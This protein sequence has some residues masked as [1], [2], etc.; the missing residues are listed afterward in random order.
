MRKLPRRNADRFGVALIAA[1]LWSAACAG[2]RPDALRDALEGR[3]AASGA[4][5][6]LYFRDLRTGD[7][8]LVAPDLR[9]HAASM[10]KVPV[11]IQV[12]RDAEAGRLRLEDTVAVT[13]AF[14]SIMDGSPYEL[15]IADDSDR[16]LY[17]RRRATVRELVDRMITVSSNLA[18]NLLIELVGA[19]RVTRTMR[20]LGADS[21][22]VLRGVEDIK[23]YEAG[24]SN[25]TTA[26]DLGVIFGAIAECRAASPA[27]CGGM[28][29]ILAR[30]A[31][32]GGIPAG[33]PAGTRV[34]HKT[35]RITR[36]HHDGGIVYLDDEPAYV[37]VVL[38]RG[39]EDPEEADRL[40]ADLVEIVHANIMDTG[41]RT[42]R[43]VY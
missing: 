4:E 28:L 19:E 29:E 14:S 40:I 25:T 11:M 20:D 3:I 9:L 18:A 6:G 33:L 32:R 10:M 36:I 7:S 41:Q 8:V 24:L 39:I 17:G 16:L 30:Q 23:A 13:R 15:S 21:I 26:R 22:E 34:A 12:F 27:S 38:T 35:G 1:A 5:V 31:F 37:L 2:E 43:N 42:T